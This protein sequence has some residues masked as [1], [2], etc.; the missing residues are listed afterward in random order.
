MFR[1]QLWLS[2]FSKF[3]SVIRYFHHV[4]NIFSYTVITKENLRSAHTGLF[5]WFWKYVKYTTKLLIFYKFNQVEKFIFPSNPKWRPLGFPISLKRTWDI[6]ETKRWCSIL[7][8]SQ[9][10]NRF[11]GQRKT[12]SLCCNTLSDIVFQNSAIFE[13]LNLKWNSQNLL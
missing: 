3:K 1:N 5:K 4:I 13:N 7:M 11:I 9:Y 6:T 10:L 12:F 8:K 2:F